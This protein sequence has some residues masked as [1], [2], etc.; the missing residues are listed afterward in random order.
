MTQTRTPED[1]PAAS[2]DRL[3]PF[4]ATPGRNLQRVYS[5]DTFVS[6]DTPLESPMFA[7]A[8]L[9]GGAVLRGLDD[10]SLTPRT[11]R[12]P[13]WMGGRIYFNSDRT[14]T[15]NLYEYDPGS[16][17]VKALT[18][19]AKWDVR[20]PSRGDQGRIVY[21][22]DGELNVLDVKSGQ[23][24]KISINVPS[25]G[26]ASRPSLVNVGCLLYTSPSPR[27]RTRSRMP[28]SA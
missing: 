21:E 11:E 22:A 5:S 27:D 8:P 15:F 23:A 2:A 14:G 9:G 19:S 7:F 28:S 6:S 10:G 26:L 17:K 4:G 16:K 24:K 13:M 20:W 25:D 18:S 3:R 1:L 12:E